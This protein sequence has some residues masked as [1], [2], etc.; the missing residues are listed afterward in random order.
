MSLSGLSTVTCD[1][2]GYW[3]PRSYLRTRDARRT[4]AP[5]QLIAEVDPELYTRWAQWAALLPLMRFHGVGV[6]EPIAYPEPARSAGVAACRFRKT[7]QPYV[8]EAAR[9]ASKHGTPIIQPMVLAYPGDRAARDADLQYLFGPNILV[10]PLLEPGGVRSLWVPPGQW[11]P[12]VGAPQVDGPGWTTVSCALD[13]FAVWHRS[14]ALGWP[15]WA[16]G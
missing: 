4:M 1:A 14:D 6:R 7:L 13:Q 9:I 11:Q 16:A 5:R 8:I 10:A 12:M 3:T 2:G 15:G